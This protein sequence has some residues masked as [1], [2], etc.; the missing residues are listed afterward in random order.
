[1]K[2]LKIVILLGM[3]LLGAVLLTGCDYNKQIFDTPFKFT[4]AITYIGR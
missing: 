4:K 1:M 2:K 3:I